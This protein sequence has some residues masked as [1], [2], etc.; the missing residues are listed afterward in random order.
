[1]SIYDEIGNTIVW[2]RKQKEMTQEWLALECEISISYLR[3]IEHGTANP[4]IG[5]L[6]IIARA[7]DMELRNP[8]VV[9]VGAIS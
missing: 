6:Y 8:L 5:E 7:L 1:M 2:M 3:R 9:P 4:T